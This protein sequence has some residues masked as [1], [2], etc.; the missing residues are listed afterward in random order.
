MI[1]MKKI[2]SKTFYLCL[3]FAVN[4]IVLT[5]FSIV[6]INQFDTQENYIVNDNITN[7]NIQPTTNSRYLIQKKNFVVYDSY[8]VEIK[9]TD[10]TY[11]TYIVD[12]CN[13]C[14]GQEINKNDQIGLDNNIAIYAETD[15]FCLDIQK[16]NSGYKV[17]LYNYNAFSV[18]F[19]M[20]V[21]DFYRL[22]INEKEVFLKC[23]GDYSKLEFKGYDYSSVGSNNTIKA[24]FSTLDCDLLINSNS[25][26]TLEI[27]KNEYTNQLYLPA[28]LFDNQLVYKLFYIIKNNN[29]YAI[30]V[31]SFAIVDEYALIRSEDYSLKEGMFLYLYE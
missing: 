12:T 27:K 4:V 22:A 31:E 25:T 3:L 30:Y 13:I 16:E 10:E 5:C 17:L 29:I 19:N 21:S 18:E 1:I 20:S 23:F 26:C 9:E 24:T 2:H 11:S 7:N 14:V 15:S 6:T 8:S 28:S